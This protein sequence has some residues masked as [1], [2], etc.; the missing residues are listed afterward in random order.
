MR[1]ITTR[2]LLESKYDSMEQKDKD[3]YDDNL[4]EELAMS[5]GRVLAPFVTK[6]ITEVDMTESIGDKA[7]RKC[8]GIEEIPKTSMIE[9]KFELDIMTPEQRKFL[10]NFL[11]SKLSELELAE[12]S[13]LMIDF[14]NAN[15]DLVNKK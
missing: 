8:R 10:N 12:F 5:V 1:L 6:S 7:S 13:Y 9:W 11:A 2:H 3:L 15:A 14:S 4:P